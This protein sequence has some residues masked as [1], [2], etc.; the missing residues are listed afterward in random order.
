MPEP[1]NG[2][3][4]AVKVQPGDQIL[5]TAAGFQ[6]IGDK[7]FVVVNMGTGMIATTLV[8]EP[9][10]AKQ[11]ARSIKEAAEVAEVQIIKPRSMLAEA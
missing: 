10:A 8:L 3:A 9:D 11:L 4:P 5:A 2:P 6:Q 1:A 7:M